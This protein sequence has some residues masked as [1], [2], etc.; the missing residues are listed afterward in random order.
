M[1]KGKIRSIFA[2]AKR[3]GVAAGFCSEKFTVYWFLGAWNNFS[4]K[5]RKD[6]ESNKKGYFFAAAFKGK[7]LTGNGR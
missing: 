2:A 7:A 4:K 1:R 6:L 5:I 3:E